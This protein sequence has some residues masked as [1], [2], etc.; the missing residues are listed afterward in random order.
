MLPHTGQTIP[1]TEL[2]PADPDSPL[3]VEWET[4]RREVGRLLAEGHEG[5]FVV[6]RG[7]EIAGLHDTWEAARV[8]GLK[9]YLLNPHLVRPILRREP[10]LRGPI[11]QR[12]CRT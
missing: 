10:V 5:R 11:G 12:R 4:Y 1:Y 8:A 2:P 9:K 6:I 3:A 7:A